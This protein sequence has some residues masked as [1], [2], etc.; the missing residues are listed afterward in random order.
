MPA[1]LS[2]LFL[3]GQVFAGIPCP[4]TQCRVRRKAR[5]R[6]R[7]GVVDWVGEVNDRRH[8]RDGELGYQGI[9]TPIETTV[10]RLQWN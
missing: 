9:D 5:Q 10:G 6:T 3:A 4:L 1:A 7:A 2:R 8:G